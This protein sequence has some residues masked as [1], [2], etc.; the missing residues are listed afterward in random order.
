MSLCRTYTRSISKEKM[1][2]AGFKRPA[3]HMAFKRWIPFAQLQK[4]G[5]R[6]MKEK[7]A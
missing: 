2:K 4:K 7:A 6:K 5:R 3:K 1:R